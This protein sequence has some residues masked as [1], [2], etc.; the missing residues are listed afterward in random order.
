MK[1]LT[2]KTVA[3][4]KPKHE[5]YEIWDGNGFGVRVTP[6][7]T[8]SWVLVYH[9]QG[10]PRRMTLGTY[11]GMG[12]ADARIRLARGTE[13]T[14][15]GREGPR[16]RSCR[17]ETGGE[18]GGDGFRSRGELSGQA[19]QQKTKRCRRCP[20]HEQGRAAGLGLPQGERHHPPGRDCA[21]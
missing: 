6:R 10:R 11:P 17:R 21:A 1:R 18:G 3:A 8:K 16:Q 14:R 4:L 7:G 9:H 12:L 13:T 5:R 19:R 2:D 15:G 20:H